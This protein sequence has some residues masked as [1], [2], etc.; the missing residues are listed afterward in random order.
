MQILWQYLRTSA[1]FAI[2][3]SYMDCLQKM[4]CLVISIPVVSM[5]TPSKVLVSSSSSLV[6]TRTR[7]PRTARSYQMNHRNA[8]CTCSALAALWVYSD[9]YMLEMKIH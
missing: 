3:L 7:S 6:S 2:F 1:A 5:M 8:R 4:R 9:R